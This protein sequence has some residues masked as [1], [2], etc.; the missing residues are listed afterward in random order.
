MCNFGNQLISQSTN[1]SMKIFI[2]VSKQ[3]ARKLRH[4]EKIQEI[5]SKYNKEN[6][7]VFGKTILCYLYQKGPSTPDSPRQIAHQTSPNDLKPN[8]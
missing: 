6:Y 1:Q 8:R 4:N 3:L 7:N 2:S 5:E